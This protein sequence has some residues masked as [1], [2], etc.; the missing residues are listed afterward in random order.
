MIKYRASGGLKTCRPGTGYV[1]YD[2][3]T[4]PIGD[5][6]WLTTELGIERLARATADVDPG[7]EDDG[8]DGLRPTVVALTAIT[9]SAA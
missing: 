5:G 9:R 6:Y 4:Q 7:D 8:M 2:A 3:W 1:F